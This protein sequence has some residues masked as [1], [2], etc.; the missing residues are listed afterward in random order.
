MDGKHCY[1]VHSDFEGEA[2]TGEIIR[3]LEK[4]PIWEKNLLRA[5]LL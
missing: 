3:Q 1:V 5:V 4:V 2:G